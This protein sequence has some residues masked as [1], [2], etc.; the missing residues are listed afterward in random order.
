M[1]DDTIDDEDP[2]VFD[3]INQQRA[4]KEEDRRQ[5][6]IADIAR[7]LAKRTGF[8]AA[9]R[10]FI[11]EQPIYYDKS[12]IWWLWNHQNTR[13]EITD[14]TDVLTIITMW[15]NLYGDATVK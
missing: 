6:H 9:A 7:R 14:E 12:R 2:S 1:A 10:E 11:K 5:E 3:Q 15:G 4:E 8:L 13:W